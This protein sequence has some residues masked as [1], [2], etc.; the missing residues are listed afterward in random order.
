VP[1]PRHKTLIV[2]PLPPLATK[3]QP[4]ATK[5][6]T[7]TKKQMADRPRRVPG[8]RGNAGT[9]TAFNAPASPPPAL[10]GIPPGRKRA[11]PPPDLDYE[12]VIPLEEMLQGLLLNDGEPEESL[13]SVFPSVVKVF[14]VHSFPSYSQPWQTR[15]QQMSTSTGFII[16]GNRILTNAHSVESYSRVEL[17][18]RGDSN[19]YLAKV[20]A[21]GKDCDIALLCIA[22]P[23]DETKF[24]KDVAPIDVYSSSRMFPHLQERIAVVGFPTGGDNL[25][26]SSGVVSRL[27]MVSYVNGQFD[28]PA[29]QTDAAINSGNSGG[30]AFSLGTKQF[31]GI[32]FQSLTNAD[33]IG[34]VIPLAIVRH[35][36]DD[37]AKNGRYT[38]FC[39]L[40]LEGQTLENP[41]IRKYLG[42]RDD[43]TGVL[44]TKIE[45]LA[46]CKGIVQVGDVILEMDGHKLGNDQSVEFPSE[47]TMEKTDVS[48]PHDDMIEIEEDD[49]L[50]PRRASKSGTSPTSKHK[51]RRKSF[52]KRSTSRARDV[53]SDEEIIVEEDPGPGRTLGSTE[54]I[55]ASFVIT[56]K[57]VGDVIPLKLYRKGVGEITVNVAL[58]A[59]NLLVDVEG[60]RVKPNHPCLR[61]PSWFVVSGFVFTA[62]TEAYINS[63]FGSTEQGAAPLDMLIMW[64][65]GEK[66]LPDEQIVLLTESLAHSSN[67]GYDFLSNM[68]LAKVHG[69]CEVA[70][71]TVD[72]RSQGEES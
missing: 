50:R 66:R 30:P 71:P 39:T 16:A 62:L 18:R 12:H 38:G 37:V 2:Y 22:S 1:P 21:I 36:L 44:V 46:P 14:C 34:Y 61:L 57:F 28:L 35:F 58:S 15:R 47:L 42:L 17:R 55:D 11:K 68:R 24:F 7:S 5:K 52:G 49:G 29:I 25:S 59:P 54:R 72:S 6:T 3:K 53:E 27:D 51:K 32:A 43:Q 70:N 19:K 65:E 64:M 56:Q 9:G 45:E 40:A 31:A 33:N 48:V 60:S 13:Q 63:E 26:I 69:L 10:R 67:V 23:D 4:L 20:L 41:I 8:Q